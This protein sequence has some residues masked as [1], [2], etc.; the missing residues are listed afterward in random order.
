MGNYSF[1]ASQGKKG[2]QKPARSWWGAGLLTLTI[3]MVI[4]FYD[5]SDFR[6]NMKGYFSNGHEKGKKIGE[7]IK[8]VS[9]EQEET[10]PGKDIVVTEKD[11]QGVY[12]DLLQKKEK[13][14]E[15]VTILEPEKGSYYQI[16][17]I[18]GRTLIA[19]TIQLDKKMAMITDKQGMVISIDR[20]EIAG[21]KKIEA[22]ANSWK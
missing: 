19:V 17:L 2:R 18:T 6:G 14:I 13:E 12:K 20:R 10:E 16:D 21:I 11:L 22:K 15:K 9:S 8:L 4:V 3:V 7:G 1:D 5:F